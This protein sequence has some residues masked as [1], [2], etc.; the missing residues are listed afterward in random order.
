VQDVVF[1][2]ET[3]PDGIRFLP[4]VTSHQRDELFA[5]RES[6]ELQNF[7]Y[8]GKTIRV[9]VHLPAVQKNRAGV[10]TIGKIVLNGKNIGRDFVA[11]DALQNQNEWDV[12]L[13]NPRD[14]ER[15]E[16]LNLIADLHDGRTIYGPAQPQWKDVGEGGITMKNRL[17]ALHFLCATASNVVFNIYRN[18]EI[19]AGKITVTDWIDPR[20]G[21]FPDRTYFYTVEALD[22]LTGNASHLSPT[23]FFSATNDQ[24]EIPA[25]AMENRGGSLADGRYFMDWGKPEHELL[26]KNFNA[27]RSGEYVLRTEFSNGAGPVNTGI[28]CAVK[29]IEVRKTGSGE[30]VAAGYLVMP[31]TGD[32]QRFDLSSVVRARLA[33]GESYSLRIFED[34]YSRNMSYLE[35][36]ERYTSWP[37]G[38]TNAYNFVNI[39][40]IRL[41]HIA[42]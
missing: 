18:G 40:A 32:W 23:H 37:G 22:V 42:D 5:A 27:P 4:F 19:C 41:W 21:D 35:K 7:V 33:A 26:V 6:L 15:D 24:W 12:Y 1:G 11:A 39:A 2:L 34:E 28:T 13:Q 3:A 8:Q 30:I 17:L 38:G 14:G 36:N 25:R 20:S 16:T 31:Q 9:R 29:K 10:L